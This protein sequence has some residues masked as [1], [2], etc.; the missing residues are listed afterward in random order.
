MFE[1][2]QR[3]EEDHPW[4]SKSHN[5]L[6]LPAPPRGVAVD[7]AFPAGGFRRAEAAGGEPGLGVVREG[8]AFGAEARFPRAAVFAPAIV[9]YHEAHDALFLVDPVCIRHPPRA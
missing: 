6:D 1:I 3:H 2:F 7:A 8:G 9:S 4:T 5:V